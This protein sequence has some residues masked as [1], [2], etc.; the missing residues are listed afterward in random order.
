M[1]YFWLILLMAFALFAASCKEDT[2]VEPPSPSMT[3]LDAPNALLAN[4]DSCYLYRVRITN[5]QLSDV[6]VLISGPDSI[7]HPFV[8]LL[9][10]GGST[11]ILD[12]E[13]ACDPSGDIVP[14][15]GI[16]TGRINARILAQ[17]V[18][19]SWTFRFMTGDLPTEERSIQIQNAEPCIITSYPQTQTFETCFA[20][21]MLEVRVARTEGDEVDS[22]RVVIGQLAFPEAADTLEFTPAQADTVWRAQLTP[23]FFECLNGADCF[24]TYAAHTRFGMTCEQTIT[25][26]SY[27]N[28]LPVLSNSTLPDTIFHPTGTGEVDSVAFTADLLDCELAGEQFYYGMKYSVRRRDRTEWTDSSAYVFHDDG[29]SP[30]VTAGDG[31]FTAGIS[32]RWDIPDSLYYFRFYALECA[33]PGDT[34]A[35][36]MDSVQ[37]WPSP[38]AL[39]RERDRETR[40]EATFG[41]W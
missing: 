9:D 20:P 37:I 2:I 30:D 31:T 36:L 19:G 24:L 12:P 4:A 32:I 13:Y 27:T 17:G 7:Y 10:D 18:T 25:D 34:S 35:F 15:D 6:A 14:N 41:T 5:L 23:T 39:L 21:M 33:P 28:S 8:R 38:G 3:I 16:F 1:K 22:V 26:V 40:D 29:F 11:T